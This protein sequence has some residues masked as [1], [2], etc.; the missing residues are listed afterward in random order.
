MFL[1]NSLLGFIVHLLIECKKTTTDANLRT[2][3]GFLQLFQ[4]VI[5]LF[6]VA[7][8][9][10]VIDKVTGACMFCAIVFGAKESV[11]HCK[12]K[13]V[14]EFDQHISVKKLLSEGFHIMNFYWERSGQWI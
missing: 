5:L 8:Y 4:S 11:Q 2:V 1:I 9:E 12:V 13:L 6:P 3:I 14:D 10:S 7:K